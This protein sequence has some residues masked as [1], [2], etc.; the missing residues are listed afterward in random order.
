MSQAT[1]LDLTSSAFKA[2]PYPAF[3]RLR[4]DDPVHLL[5]SSNEQNTWLI[6]R[7]EDAQVV[8][9]DERFV[10]NRRNVCAPQELTPT[11]PSAADL[12]GMSMSMLKCD[13]P[14]HTRLR[15]LVN[16]SFT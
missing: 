4:A 8:L 13:P 2:N 1:E 5:T 12:M 10:K 9:R 15:S 16:L 6:T 7:Y 14:D 11:P 3:A